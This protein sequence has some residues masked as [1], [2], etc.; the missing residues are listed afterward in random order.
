[1]TFINL[2]KLMQNRLYRTHQGDAEL[3]LKR[4]LKEDH[5]EFSFYLKASPNSICILYQKTFRLILLT[6]SPHLSRRT[7]SF[8]LVRSREIS[9]V[10]DDS[11]TIH[12]DVR[13]NGC[14]HDAPL[15]DSTEEVGD[16]GAGLSEAQSRP[17]YG[18]DGGKN[19]VGGAASS[20]VICLDAPMEGA[21]IPSDHMAGCMSC[22]NEIKAKKW[23]CPVCRA[24]ID[25][26]KSEAYEEYQS[27]P[28]SNSPVV[29]EASTLKNRCTGGYEN[30]EVEGILDRLGLRK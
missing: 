19:G 13:R 29:G 9:L 6:Y 20:C 5:S 28:G 1:M 14:D 21:C 18:E 7:K 2:S 15:Q 10:G 11:A 30:G 27:I 26:Q 8:S 24:K 3:Q 22:L 4:V 12:G 25:Q 16:H 23:G 17:Y